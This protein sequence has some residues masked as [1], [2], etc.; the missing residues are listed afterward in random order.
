MLYVLMPSLNRPHRIEPVLESLATA[1][2][3]EYVVLWAVSD[4]E[5]ADILWRN[6]QPA[7]H[8]GNEDDQR[9]VTRNNK[10]AQW[11]RQLIK[12]ENA[13]EHWVFFGSDDYRW[14]PGWFTAAL[15]CGK[16]FVIPFDK[17]NPNGTAALARMDILD[18]LVVDDPEAVFHHGYIHNFADTEQFE[19]ANAHGLV[20]RPRD[21][22]VEHLHHSTGKLPHDSTYE[23]AGRGWGPDA[24]LFESRKHLWRNL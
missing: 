21:C 17:V 10:L 19:T 23:L 8:D 24:Q 22:I 14:H 12:G 3:H 13:A 16:P 15:D 4:A 20:G 6:A 11:A 9:Y 7:I 2:P 1:T 5:S 18:K